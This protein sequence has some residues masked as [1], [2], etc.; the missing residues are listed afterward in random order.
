MYV[1][2]SGHSGAAMGGAQVGLAPYRGAP[3]TV[4]TMRRI[5]DRDRK[6]PEARAAAED[7]V[8][9]I[10]AKD[11]LSEAAALYYAVCRG[12]RYTRDPATVE[13]VKDLEV[14]ARTRQN[15]CDEM[16]ANLMTLVGQ[17]GVGGTQFVTVGFRPNGQHSH[18]FLR[19]PDPRGSGRFVVLDP[20][21]GPT[22]A[23]ML[24]RIQVARVYE[25]F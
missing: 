20:V 17:V 15:D 8:R 2:L 22:T 5:V 12:V 11:Y 1:A 14:S 18:V 4:E 13:L 16:S 23:T 7:V 19:F 9:G 10:Y 24:K 25:G 6:N 3:H 21:A